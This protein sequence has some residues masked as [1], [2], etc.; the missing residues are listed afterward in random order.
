MLLRSGRSGLEQE[1]KLVWRCLSQET[2]FEE[3]GSGSS[4]SVSSREAV[5]AAPLFVGFRARSAHF[6]AKLRGPCYAVARRG[7]YAALRHEDAENGPVVGESERVPHNAMQTLRI[8]RS[9]RRPGVRSQVARLFG[10][11]GWPR[12]PSNGPSL[13]SGVGD[14]AH[15]S[16]AGV[17]SGGQLGCRATS[18]PVRSAHDLRRQLQGERRSAQREFW[19]SAPSMWSAL[20]ALWSNAIQLVS[21]TA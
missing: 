13:C 5:T 16:G 21:Y 6:G 18:G 3:S 17:G 14:S 8:R 20:P 4:Y 9:E 11:E 1:R 12:G 10:D 19:S 15:V 7:M 2:E